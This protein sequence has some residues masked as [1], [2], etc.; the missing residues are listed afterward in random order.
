[1]YLQY[2]P[3]YVIKPLF[4]STVNNGDICLYIDH[5]DEGVYSSFLGVRKVFT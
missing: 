2:V 4:I 1:M 3:V 5:I